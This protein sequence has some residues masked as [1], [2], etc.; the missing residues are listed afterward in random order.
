MLAGKGT[1]Y[2]ASMQYGGHPVVKHIK[3]TQSSEI[4]SLQGSK[5]VQSAM[6]GIIGDCIRTAQKAPVLFVGTPCQVA[7]LRNAAG[8]HLKN[9]YTVDL[10]C[11]GV[12][13]PGLF[14]RYISSLGGNITFFSFR[15]KKTGWETGSTIYSKDEETCQ[16]PMAGN[17]FMAMYF[18]GLSMRP[19]CYACPFS[20]MER[21]GD[22]TI[23]DFWGVQKYYPWLDDKKG[24]SLVMVNSPKGQELWSAVAQGFDSVITDAQKSFQPRLGGPTPAPANRSEFFQDMGRQDFSYLYHRYVRESER[25]RMMSMIR[26]RIDTGENNP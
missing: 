12:S 11:N 22:I 21:T 8:N 16:T 20:S 26:R 10:I 13:S 2:G 24:T 15:S 14:Q 25:R 9:L 19:S 23:G 1:V 18:K 4:S 6:D 17:P 7:G 3:I 5:Y